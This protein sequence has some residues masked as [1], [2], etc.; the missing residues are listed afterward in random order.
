MPRANIRTVRVMAERG[1]CAQDVS[2]DGPQA[3]NEK[4]PVL[5]LVIQNRGQLHASAYRLTTLRL[6]SPGK[7]TTLWCLTP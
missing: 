5:H 1:G 2:Y 3:N 7:A 6:V 4:S